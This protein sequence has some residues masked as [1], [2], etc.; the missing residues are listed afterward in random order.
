MTTQDKA[1]RSVLDGVYDAWAANDA[2]AFVGWYAEDATAILPGT[3]LKDRSAIRDAMAAEFAG[4]LKGSRGIEEVQ[5]VRFLGEDVAVVIGRSNIVLTGET[6]P[7][8]DRWARET[9]TLSKRTG[10][11]LV[12]A[13]HQAPVDVV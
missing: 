10:S 12:E 2:D 3:C 1:V 5:Y 11:W 9:W 7:P 4:S 6:E 8:A 13:Y